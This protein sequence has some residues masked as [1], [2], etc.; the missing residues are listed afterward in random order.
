MLILKLYIYTKIPTNFQNLSL[1]EIFSKAY[2]EIVL[3][4]CPC[5]LTILHQKRSRLFR[6]INISMINIL[7]SLLVLN[8]YC[9]CHQKWYMPQDRP[10]NNQRDNAKTI[11]FLMLKHFRQ[12]CWRLSLIYRAT[13]FNMQLKYLKEGPF[14][15]DK[16]V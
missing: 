3:L 4:K 11:Q 7:L 8:N 6:V 13:I 14:L 10:L 12:D 2:P 9:S 16:F 15:L 5:H 1:L